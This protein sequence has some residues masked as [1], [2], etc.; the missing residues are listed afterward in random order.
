MDIREREADDL[1][2]LPELDILEVNLDLG[3]SGKEALADD[4]ELDA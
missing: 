1:L 2:L 3:V 4:S